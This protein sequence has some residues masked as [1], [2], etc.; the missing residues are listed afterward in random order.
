MFHTERLSNTQIRR[1]LHIPNIQDDENHVHHEQL[2]YSLCTKMI[3]QHQNHQSTPQIVNR[4]L[5]IAEIENTSE[6]EDW[7][8][9]SDFNESTLF[10]SHPTSNADDEGVVEASSEE[11]FYEGPSSGVELEGHR[12]EVRPKGDWTTIRDL[13]A[14]IQD[15]L[16][17]G[18]SSHK[19]IAPDACLG[20]LCKHHTGGRLN[21]QRLR[22]RLAASGLDNPDT[23]YVK[24]ENE[25]AQLSRGD[26]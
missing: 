14:S 24:S 8:G 3:C 16:H 10:A 9:I 13:V 19:D 18:R 17:E 22:L 11:D 5:D 25:V 21:L 23:W 7:E 1:I 12:T 2:P 4:V 6:Q 15:A 26:N 20:L